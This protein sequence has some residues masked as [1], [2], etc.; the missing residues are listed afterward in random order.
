MAAAELAASIES[1]VLAVTGPLGNDRRNN[2][3]SAF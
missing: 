3:S 1:A 2:W